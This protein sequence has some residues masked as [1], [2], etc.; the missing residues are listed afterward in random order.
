MADEQDESNADEL[1]QLLVDQMREHALVLLNIEGRI[2][3]WYAGAEKLFGYLPHE[4]IGK[5]VSILFTPENV[6]AGMV[7][8]EQAVAQTDIE[9]EDDRWMLRKNGGRFWATG[10]LAPI[11]NTGGQ[12]VGFG[13]ILRD[14]TDVRAELQALAK[15]NDNLKQGEQRKNQFIRTLSHELRNPMASL[16][17]AAELFELAADDPKTVRETAATLKSELAT[18]RRMIDDLIDVTRV[19]AGKVQLDKKCQDLRPVIEAAVAT[20]RPNIDTRT[21]HLNVIIPSAP[22]LVDLD[23]VRMRQVF[24]NLIQNSAKY[25]E[26][27]GTIWIKA[28]V[29]AGE[30]VVKIEDNGIGISPDL[31]PNI[32]DLFTQAEFAGDRAAEGLGIGLSVVKDLTQLH[33]G[34]VQ[35]R[36]DG[37][38]KGSEF[39]VRLPLV[40]CD[41]APTHP[42]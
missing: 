34:S 16:V 25:T 12:L 29:E 19:S 24:V 22:M 30:A 17:L 37:L 9:A 3:G 15:Q 31:L 41:G 36:S 42:G 27:G 20:C 1:L 23:G 38:G 14:R 39:T 32:F 10:V 26:N 6:A 18:M 33:G 4:V 7:E 40:N 2:V 28:S 13:K 21:H 8:Y 11:R 35:V 5:P